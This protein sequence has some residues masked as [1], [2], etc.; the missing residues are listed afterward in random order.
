MFLKVR[1]ESIVSYTVTPSNTY[2][3]SELIILSILAVALE[4]P[5]SNRWLLPVFTFCSYC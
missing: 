4:L 2:S 3:S 1:L 5:E